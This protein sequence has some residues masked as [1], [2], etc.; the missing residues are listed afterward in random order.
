LDWPLFDGGARA[1]R[2]A[3]A[4]AEVAAAHAAL[5]HA[6]DAAVQQV[7]DAYDSLRLVR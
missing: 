3:T 4:R 5:D 2:V 6:R 1:A 7:T